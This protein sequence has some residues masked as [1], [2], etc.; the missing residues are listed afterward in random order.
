MADQDAAFGSLDDLD[1]GSGPGGADAGADG[2]RDAD[3]VVGQGSGLAAEDG[4]QEPSGSLE[5][6]QPGMGSGAGNS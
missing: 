5:G 4:P 3:Q 6:C 1:H 2:D